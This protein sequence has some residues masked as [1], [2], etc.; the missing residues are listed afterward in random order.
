MRGSDL[1][2]LWYS[3]VWKTRFLVLVFLMLDEDVWASS[4]VGFLS[5]LAS[6][7]T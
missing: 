4:R 6:P 2:R 5:V 7:C 3:F 1:P